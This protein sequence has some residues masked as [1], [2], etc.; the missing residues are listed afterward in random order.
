M[1]LVYPLFMK[2]KFLMNVF[3]FLSCI[4]FFIPFETYFG[5]YNLRNYTFKEDK[6]IKS[7]T[8]DEIDMEEI[9]N[10]EISI[11]DNSDNLV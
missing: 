5:F 6:S 2:I 4:V 7:P 11:I 9:D 8:L 3:G 10:V 1:L